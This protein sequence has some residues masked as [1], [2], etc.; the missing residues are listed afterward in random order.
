MWLSGSRGA[1]RTRDGPLLFPWVK[2]LGPGA[3]PC[4]RQPYRAA[5]A[6]SPLNLSC[7]PATLRC[8]LRWQRTD[9]VARDIPR[10]FLALQACS[11]PAPRPS[12][13]RTVSLGARPAGDGGC[14]LPEWGWGPE[15]PLSLRPQ[16]GEEVSYNS[17]SQTKY[18]KQQLG[19]RHHFLIHDL[20]PEDAGIYQVKVEDA[21]VFSTELEASGE[22]ASRGSAGR[23]SWLMGRAHIGAM[24]GEGETV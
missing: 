3:A 17:G 23:Q 13:S 18:S 9:S 1:L 10:A 5:W 14:P 7:H 6:A 4:S 22:W 11:P 16:D 20:W 2:A 24:A 19:N 8:H 21:D 15:P 12:G